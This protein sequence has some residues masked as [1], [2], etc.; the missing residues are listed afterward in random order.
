MITPLLRMAQKEQGVS[1]HLLTYS[2]P[3]TRKMLH[4]N[5]LS[6]YAIPHLLDKYEIPAWLKVEVGFFAGRLYFEWH[7]YHDILR[8]LG[9]EPETVETRPFTTACPEGSTSLNGESIAHENSCQ[10]FTTR[11]LAFLEDW[12]SSRRKMQDWSS[13]PMGFIVAGKK[14]HASHAFFSGHCRTVEE[15]T[16]VAYV[17]EAEEKRDDD[18]DEDDDIFYDANDQ[19]VGGAEVDWDDRKSDDEE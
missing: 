16:K 9:L 17:A 13:S 15:E 7:E 8:F 19:A 1:V 11:P 14:L 3:V 4:F 5:D 10:K 18:E 12:I 6:Y 2:A